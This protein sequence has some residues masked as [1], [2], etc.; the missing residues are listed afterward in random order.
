MS[1]EGQVANLGPVE[2]KVKGADVALDDVAQIGWVL[3]YYDSGEFVTKNGDVTQAPAEGKTTNHETNAQ[4]APV[5]PSPKDTLTERGSIVKKD[6]V[7][8]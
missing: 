5:Y 7:K 4:S 3:D 2:W 1:A 8:M 6:D